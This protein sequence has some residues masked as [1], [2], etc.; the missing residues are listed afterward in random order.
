M[1]PTR[2]RDAKAIRAA[3]RSY[4]KAACAFRDAKELLRKGFVAAT[5]TECEI[6]HHPT[7]GLN[8]EDAIERVVIKEAIDIAEFYDRDPDRWP[9]G[10]DA[11]GA[12]ES[13]SRSVRQRYAKGKC[14]L[15]KGPALACARRHASG[16][17]CA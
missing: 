5:A 12:Y 14:S 1:V 10:A 2:R 9:N 13:A 7:D 6:L 15:C 3:G 11:A 8:L 16:R 17:S 4:L